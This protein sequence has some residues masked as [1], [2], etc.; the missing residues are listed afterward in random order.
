MKVRITIRNMDLRL[1]KRAVIAARLKGMTIGRF[2]NQ[3]I[4]ELLDRLNS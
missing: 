1:Y 2:I 3:A 4:R